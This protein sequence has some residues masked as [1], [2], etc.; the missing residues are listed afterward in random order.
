[1]G[2]SFEIDAEEGVI[3]SIAGEKSGWKTSK[4]T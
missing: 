1:M 4:L 3:Y 2:I